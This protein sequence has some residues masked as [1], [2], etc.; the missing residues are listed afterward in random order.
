MEELESRRMIK[1]VI[2]DMYETLITHYNSPLYFG[3]QMAADAGI[4][5]ED[6]QKMWRA[7]DSERTV[8]KMTFEEIIENILKEYQCYSKEMLDLIVSKRVA[9]KEEGFRNLHPEIIPMLSGLKEK[10]MKIGLISNCF[11]EETGVIRKSVLFPYFDAVCL[12]Y[13]E[14]IKKP[15][16]EIYKRCMEKL[17][18]KPEECLYVGDGGSQ[19]LEAAKALGMETAQAVWYLKEG[20][21]QPVGRK[22]GFRHVENPLELLTLIS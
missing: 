18:V 20:T 14:G 1:T 9:T 11:S 8:G 19:E 22:D 17:G 21:K 5:E 3:K 7:T 15:D 16:A 13:E 6:F 10:G 12:S 4:S 2:F